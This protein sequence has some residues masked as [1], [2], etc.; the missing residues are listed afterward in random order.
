MIDTRK[1]EAS[2]LKISEEVIL[3]IRDCD[4]DM[5]IASQTRLSIQFIL[6]C[7]P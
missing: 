1:R 5:T 4:K 6:T 2:D 7:H 3:N